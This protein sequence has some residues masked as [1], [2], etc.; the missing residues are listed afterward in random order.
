MQFRSTL[1]TGR[2]VFQV[3]YLLYLSCKLTHRDPLYVNVITFLIDS[4]R[5]CR[6]K[7]SS[8]HLSPLYFTVCHVSCPRYDWLVCNESVFPRFRFQSAQLDTPTEDPDKLLKPQ[9]PCPSQ[10]L[11]VGSASSL[12]SPGPIHCHCRHHRYLYRSSHSA[13]KCARAIQYR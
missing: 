8:S 10:C 9:G 7:H 5:L 6:W 2:N 13:T 3:N 12:P 4:Q 1:R 11:K